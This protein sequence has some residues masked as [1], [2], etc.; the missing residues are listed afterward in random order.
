[1]KNMEEEWK[2]F[3]EGYSY[4]TGLGIIRNVEPIY[5]SNLGNVAG[6]KLFLNDNGYL[7]FCYKYKTYKVHRVVAELFIPNPEKKPCID[8]INTIRTDNRTQNLRWCSY[9]ENSNN[10]LTLKKYKKSNAKSI[11]LAT[12][13]HRKQVKCIETGETFSSAS[14]AE[15]YYNLKQHSVCNA[16]N[17]NN[18]H[19]SAGG[20]HWRYI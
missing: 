15:R 13:K 8:H 5:I 17:P 9:K 20:Y 6:R 4:K 14:E 18:S 11:K 1:M 7:S 3:R 19:Q 12:E 2:L 10:P 16:A